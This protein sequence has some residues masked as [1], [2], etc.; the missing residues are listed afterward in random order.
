[1]GE[2][3]DKFRKEREKRGISL[4]DVSNATKI[5]SRM[6]LAIENEQFD[7]LPGGVFNKGFIR[8]YAQQIG[9]NEDQAVEDYTACLRQSQYDSQD[10]WDPQARGSSSADS[11]DDEELPGL[12]LPRA[13][14]VSSAREIYGL[15]R[16]RPVPWRILFLTLLVIVLATLLWQRHSHTTS[17]RAAVPPAVASAPPASQPAPP[18]AAAA[19]ASVSPSHSTSA[20]GSARPSTVKTATTSE[21]RALTP[22][23]IK[24]SSTSGQTG[25]NDANTKLAAP[26][27]Q[28]ANSTSLSASSG[29][30]SLVIRASEN[31][32]I[33]V[34]ADGRSI[35]HE[36]LIAPAHTTVQAAHEI[37]VR[38][39]NAGGVTFVWNGRELPA[40]GAEGEVKTLVFD[41][42]GMRDVSPAAAPAQHQ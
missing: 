30:L 36:L 31:S 6:L 10:V 13:E 37:T 33:S 42:N 14:H 15:R 40:Q 34:T 39:G 24:P 35:I 18:T 19:S 23:V 2:F 7:R 8:A 26:P 25:G 12:Q 17:T 3:G 28:L 22:E 29:P 21:K 32:W 16:D 1:M 5:S 41:E 9:L 20:P 11:H 4:E 27:N 38:A